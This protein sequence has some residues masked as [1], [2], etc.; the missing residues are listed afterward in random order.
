MRAGGTITVTS[1]NQL[2]PGLVICTSVTD[3]IT[4]SKC[5]EKSRENMVSLLINSIIVVLWCGINTCSVA[6]VTSKPKVEITG[7][8]I[9]TSAA[10]KINASKEVTR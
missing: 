6:Q 2:R 8:D 10:N 1:L 7:T 5:L 3:V 9:A 4:F